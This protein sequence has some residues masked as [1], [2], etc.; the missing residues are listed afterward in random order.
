MLTDSVPHWR[1]QG[2]WN[3]EGFEYPLYNKAWTI[4]QVNPCP[5]PELLSSCLVPPLHTSIV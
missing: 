1:T 3:F 4:K 5:I 2:I